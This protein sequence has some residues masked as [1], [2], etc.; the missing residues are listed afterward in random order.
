MSLAVNL[1]R[2]MQEPVRVGSWPGAICNETIAVTK[3]A[4]V[5]AGGLWTLL[6]RF[7]AEATT[8]PTERAYAAAATDYVK[9][10]RRVIDALRAPSEDDWGP[11]DA[12]PLVSGWDDVVRHPL[13]LPRTSPSGFAAFDDGRRRSVSSA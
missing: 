4:F 8:W 10:A 7:M 6:S 3:D 5:A 11:D 1:A 9:D 12:D 2:I 13:T